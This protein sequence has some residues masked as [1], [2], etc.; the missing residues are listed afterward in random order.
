[1]DTEGTLSTFLANTALWHHIYNSSCDSE[2]NIAVEILLNTLGV[3]CQLDVRVC[4]CVLDFKMSLACLLDCT[5]TPQDLAPQHFAQPG[6]TPAA[7]NS[8]CALTFLQL[9]QLPSTQTPNKAD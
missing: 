1:V 5:R 3:V 8:P 2:V 9:L 4:F 6:D 7:T